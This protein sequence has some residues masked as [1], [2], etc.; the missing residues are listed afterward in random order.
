M[1]GAGPLERAAATGLIAAP[2]LTVAECLGWRHRASGKDRGFGNR[3]R[4]L[5]E[6]AL[7]M[8]VMLL[9]C[10]DRPVA[11]LSLDEHQRVARD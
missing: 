1:A 10:G 8:P 11:E 4:A 3:C 6:R 2:D 5:D 9:G 7:E